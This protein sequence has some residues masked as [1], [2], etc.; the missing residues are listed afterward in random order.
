[1]EKLLNY[2]SKWALQKGYKEYI[3]W[4]KNLFNR[5]QYDYQID[6]K[7]SIASFILNQKDFEYF[8]KAHDA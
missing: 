6:K 3:H 5:K 7:I 2:K 4:Y 8:K 1:M